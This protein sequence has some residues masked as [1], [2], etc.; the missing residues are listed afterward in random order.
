MFFK[1]CLIIF[2]TV[3]FFKPDNL[4]AQTNPQYIRIAKLVIDSSK[5]GQ[6]NTALKEHAEAAVKIEPGVLMLYAVQEKEH[7]ERIS[8]F[9]IYAS[10]DAYRYH[11]KTAH[12]LKYKNTVENMVKSLELI[13][14]LPIALEAKKTAN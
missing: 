9:E 5:L 8:V 12:F 3:I 6:Y 2:I 11:I 1:Y 14:V 10:V 7:P 13:D 4:S